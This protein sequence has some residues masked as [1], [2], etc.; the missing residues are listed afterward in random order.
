MKIR[1]K[2][3]KNHL[4]RISVLLL[5]LFIFF[6]PSF[7]KISIVC[8]FL[9][10]ISYL[11]WGNLRGTFT[12]ILENKL[13]ALPPLFYF[14]HLLGLI[15]TNNFNY[16]FSDLE[17]KSS[18]LFIPLLLLSFN[19]RKILLNNLE[20]TFVYGNVSAGLICLINAL[21]SYSNLNE[22]D[23]FFYEKY[24]FFLH[25]T[26]FTIYLNLSLLLVIKIYFNKLNL[27]FR[28]NFIYLLLILFLFANITLLTSRAGIVI[29]LVTSF[30]FLVYL[31]LTIP[32]YRGKYLIH[33]VIIL[34]LFASQLLVLKNFNRFAYLKY[35]IIAAEKVG[36]NTKKY[37]SEG[38]TPTRVQLWMNAFEVIKL[39]PVF[40]V[41]TGD[42]K[43]EL[44][45]IYWENKGIYLNPHNQY[46]QTAATLGSIGLLILLAMLIFP[47][48]YSIK[49]KNP[50]YILF[51]VI[52]GLNAV[53]ESILERQAGIVFFSFFYAYFYLAIDHDYS[54]Q[55]ENI[56][57]SR[58]K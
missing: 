52:I 44:I 46:L 36:G 49:K 27:S 29:T 37:D 47:I 28:S 13:L 10:G 45:R 43:D 35:E 23:V 16:A 39:H 6:L 4:N 25:P 15:Y 7:Q 31:L 57:G 22:P 53:T 51:I 17:T 38:V 30:G 32:K 56:S 48:N 41:G 42:L 40:G 33:A 5:Y 34:I 20:T 50:M 2:D 24:S 18:L 21:Y 26:Y 9:F 58:I 8:I 14:I 12:K 3:I 1:M 55:L 11:I 19:P 54:D